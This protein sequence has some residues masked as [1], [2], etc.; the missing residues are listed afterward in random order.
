[1]YTFDVRKLS[2]LNIDDYKLFMVDLDGALLTPD[3]WPKA[4]TLAVAR[5][6]GGAVKL[7]PQETFQMFKELVLNQDLYYKKLAS[8]AIDKGFPMTPEMRHLFRDQQVDIVLGLIRKAQSEVIKDHYS[9]I[10]YREGAPEV[11]GYLRQLDKKLSIVTNCKRHLF[12]HTFHNPNLRI[13][14][15][16]DSIHTA[17]TEHLTKPNPG[18]L[19]QSMAQYGIKNPREALMIGDSVPDIDVVKSPE[20]EGMDV[21]NLCDPNSVTREEQEYIDKNTTF[22]VN[23]WTQLKRHLEKTHG[24]RLNIKDDIERR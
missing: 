21:L 13:A 22:K 11:L 6:S 24:H 8:L 4:D 16:F 19:L 20:L 18:M 14:E 17:D 23:E 3:I 12:N 1:V 10:K 15:T 7:A 2:E 5:A 9:T